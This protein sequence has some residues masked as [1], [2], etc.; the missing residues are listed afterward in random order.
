VRVVARLRAWQA[1]PASG[2]LGVEVTEVAPLLVA[3]AHAA[4]RGGDGDAP[5]ACAACG[6]GGV[7][8]RAGSPMVERALGPPLAALSGVA[9]SGTCRNLVTGT[10][11]V[12]SDDVV[13]AGDAAAR[14]DEA[15][16]QLS[17]PP[18]R[19][20][21]AAVCTPH[22]EPSLRHHEA[23]TPGEQQPWWAS[24]P[25]EQLWAAAAAAWPPGLRP[26]FERPGNTDAE[27]DAAEARLAARVPPRVR[28]C[29]RACTGAGLPS[30]TFLSR[31]FPPEVCLVSAG[32]WVR[33]PA[34]LGEELG[35]S[36]TELAD[37]VVIGF[38]PE[39]ADYSQPVLLQLS[40]GVV[41][42]VTENIPEAVP[43]GAFDEWVA[44]ARQE[45]CDDPLALYTGDRGWGGGAGP[46]AP[47][48]GASAAS[49]AAAEGAAAAAASAA[50]AERH[51]FYLQFAPCGMNNA[52]RAAAWAREGGAAAAAFV[53]ALEALAAARA[54]GT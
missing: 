27:L 18:A 32:A 26:L 1:S 6:A 17:A 20:R 49:S 4:G 24:V 38:N 31:R 13:P 28:Q 11:P 15:P 37:H 30:P 33:P 10:L 41:L 5:A 23:T 36:D 12:S 44:C 50:A 22:V 43:L 53:A 19:H 25:A 39:G 47:A 7:G 3:C 14:S 8:A 46:G 48:G 54:A 40:T 29:M 2:D 42:G 21:E 34:L 51:R 16:A 9:L 35:W 52:A 45:G